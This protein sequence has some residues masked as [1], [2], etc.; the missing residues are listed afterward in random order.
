ML[1]LRILLPLVLFSLQCLGEEPP[2]SGDASLNHIKLPK[3]FSISVY[4]ENIKNARSMTLS[5]SGVLFVGNRSGGSV[6]AV[7]DEDK[8]YKADKIYTI[9]S[10]LLMPNGVAFR[11]GSLYVAEVNRILRFDDIEKKLASPPK[12]VVIRDDFPKNTH[13]GWKFIAFGPDGKLYIPVG[14]PCNVCLEKD[15]RFASIMRMNPDGSDLEVFA[16]GVRNSVGFAWH[17]ETNELWFT[18]NGRDLLGDNIPPDELNH[19]PQKGMHFGFPFLHAKTV[20]DPEF[21]K[22]ADFDSFTRPVQELGAHV[23]SLGMRFY[24]GSMFPAK[25]KNQIFIAEHGSWNRSSKIGYRISLVTL[26]GNKSTG[27]T[28]FAEGWL[29]NEKATGRPV[30]IQQL[31]DGSILVSDDYANKIYRI[32]YNK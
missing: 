1:V 26:D 8:D 27:Y 22:N 29:Q 24:T 12:P 32:T 15:K 25:Y 14:A 7:V 6:Y 3:G 10:G 4:A 16:S 28:T 17:P 11:N 19:A 18:D 5:P 13:H 20:I 23:A 2:P 31:P 21:G 30:D 9:A